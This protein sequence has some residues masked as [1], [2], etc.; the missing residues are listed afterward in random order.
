MSY[1]H[2]NFNPDKHNIY[3]PKYPDKYI[4]EYA[5][6]RSSWENDLYRWCDFNPKI[7][8]WTSEG[9]AIPYFD[10]ISKKQRRYFPDILMIVETDN[11]D[12]T[13]LVEIKPSKETK[14]PRNSARK[15][16]LTLIKESQTFITNKAKWIAAQNLCK[17]KGWI[18]KIITEKELYGK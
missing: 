17:N 9:L 3:Y 4:G 10:P 7:K 2:H 15:N 8:K 12:Q 13:F 11:G 16:K 6:C 18:F 14:Q 5:I 1:M